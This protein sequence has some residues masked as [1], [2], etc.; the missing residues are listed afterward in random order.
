MNI[1]AIEMG[2]HIISNSYCEKL[3]GVKINS[4]L[5]F[6]NYF[7]TIMKKA[8]QH[9]HALDIITP[10]MCMKQRKLIFIQR[11]STYNMASLN[12]HV[13]DVINLLYYEH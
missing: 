2:K 4:Q 11:L 12:K 9:V 6:K 13:H 3:L 7:E 8:S 5:N 10:Y 1:K